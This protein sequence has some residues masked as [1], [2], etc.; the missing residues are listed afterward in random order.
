MNPKDIIYNP[1]EAIDRTE[2][3]LQHGFPI[4]SLP[5]VARQMAQEVAEVYKVPIAMAGMSTLAV[6]SAACRDSYKMINA[7]AGYEQFGNIFVV[8][9]A[10]SGLGK[11][12]LRKVVSPL[13]ESS[14]ALAKE[15]KEKILPQLLAEKTIAE[16]ELKRMLNQTKDASTERVME[17]QAVIGRYNDSILTPPSYWV[18][19]ITGEA[20]ATALATANGVSLIYSPEGAEVIRVFSGKY[21]RDGGS[22][23]DLLLSGYSNEPANYR[24]TGK[25][26]I[27]I[28]RGV[29]SMLVATQPP[30]IANL[31][32]N[33]EAMPRGL[34]ARAMIIRC[35][36]P[37]RKDDGKN[38]QISPQVME[39]WKKLI[40]D[41]LRRSHQRNDD[42]PHVIKATEE[43][44]SLFTDFH[45]ESVD[46]A[47]EAETECLSPYLRWR[48][49]AC[50]MSI[51][52]AVASDQEVSILGSEEAQMAINLT[53]WASLRTLDW[54]K[55]A[56]RKSTFQ[57]LE[58][59]RRMIH[60]S[61][62]N[63]V[64]FRDLKQ[65]KPWSDSYLRNLIAPTSDLEVHRH[66][67]PTGRPSNCIRL[68]TTV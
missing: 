30:I 16:K 67:P 20:L 36:S 43:A 34:I 24:R 10:N 13:L 65:L 15:F 40:K 35:E 28:P 60:E 42:A 26:P 18:S 23:F 54:I 45:N 56:N 7:V 59:I 57:D 25:P 49:N 1:D 52:I 33:T 38:G 68:K 51:P 11:S 55:T 37:L 63:Y 66:K 47:N 19:N 44:R 2:S 32:K 64:T 9:G 6:L 5:D 41:L 53:R 50:R 31:I 46:L 61:E 21:R 3:V 48:E 4:D 12:S 27:N 58:I 14:H 8:I 22:D 39:R 17:L 62:D 29:L